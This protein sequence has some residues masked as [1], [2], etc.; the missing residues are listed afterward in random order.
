MRNLPVRPPSL[1][2]VAAFEAAAR[3]AS[4]T[5]AAEELNLT[6][7]A[8][9]HA[10]KALEDRLDQQL[11]IREG[12]SVALTPAGQT[13][14]AR[15]RLSLGLLSDA[16]DI[17]PW[18]T[19]DR[20]VVST[21]AS[22]AQKILLPELRTLRDA[23]GDTS[24]DFRT[25]NGLANFDDGV[26]VAIRFGPGGWR[27]VQSRLLSQE[28]LFP[29]A[30]PEYLRGAFPKDE[31][32]LRNHVLIHH[33]ESSW[34]LW[35]IAGTEP[36]TSSL[37]IDDSATVLEAA[38]AGHG[39]ALAR[40]QLARNDLSSG[41]LVRIFERS[42]LAEYGYWAVWNGSSPKRAV[43]EAF[44]DAVAWLFDAQNPDLRINSN[45]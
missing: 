22:I 5:R 43:I 21:T 6:P 25:S 36:E 44:V 27:G 10:I 24:L 12:R 3:H 39:I 38:V 45:E 30:S 15:V 34:R 9:S 26:D 7:G 4:F 18:R 14:A 28:E 8:I 37:H 2:S 33:P 17:A 41:R 29:V 31:A 16:F 13:L 11:F 1:R 20:L 19:L 42:V 32:G 40:A 23:C 35:F